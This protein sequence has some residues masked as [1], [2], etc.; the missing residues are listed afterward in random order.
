MILLVLTHLSLTDIYI[1]GD[2]DI[3]QPDKTHQLD[4]CLMHVEICL[5]TCDNSL[6]VGFIFDALTGLRNLVE[7]HL[8][9]IEMQESHAHWLVDH[10]RF[11]NTLE[12]LYVT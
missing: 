3:L 8:E 1:S 10:A 2:E 9:D 12:I 5:V 11:H 6:N 7:L 4:G